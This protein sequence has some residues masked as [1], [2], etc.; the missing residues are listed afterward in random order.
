MTRARISGEL[1]RQVAESYRH[2][3]AYCSTS[4]RIVGPLL[5]LDHIVPESRGGSSEEENLCLACPACNGHK[6]DRVSAADPER[7]ATV[8]LF[9]PRSDRW[10]EHFEWSEDGT[11]LLGK[12][13]VGRATVDVL[14]V[15][16]AD[17]VAVRRL[18]VMAGW[19]PPRD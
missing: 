16:H 8:P 3:C 19:H 12:T 7:G 1:R 18:W 6:A 10:S 14:Q 11:T 9:H 15:N 5:E 13:P 2:R 4:Q 17:M